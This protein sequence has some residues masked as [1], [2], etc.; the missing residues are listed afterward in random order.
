MQSI[1]VG[2]CLLVRTSDHIQE[3]YLK[4]N[5]IGGAGCVA[6]AQALEVRMP[7]CFLCMHVCVCICLCLRVQFIAVLVLL[8]VRVF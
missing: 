2:L 1:V 6:L 3:V 8:V 7:M 4:H 5:P